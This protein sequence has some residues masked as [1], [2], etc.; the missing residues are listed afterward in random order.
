MSKKIQ[1]S[2]AHIPCRT[3]PKLIAIAVH[4]VCQIIGQQY[5]QKQMLKAHVEKR[6]AA[7]KAKVDAGILAYDSMA[8]VM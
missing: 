6:L 4:E 3:Q 8:G 1:H 2:T 7:A 5:K